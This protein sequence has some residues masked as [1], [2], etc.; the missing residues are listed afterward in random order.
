MKKVIIIVIF[1]MVLGSGS[2]IFFQSNY[3]NIENI[4][5]IGKEKLSEIEILKYAKVKRSM[6]LL[7][8]DINEVE[9]NL[10]KHPMIYSASVEKIYPNRLSIA[11]TLRH[12]IVSIYYS[13]C[14]I[15]IDKDL[16]ALSVDQNEEGLMTVYGLDIENFNL[17]EK[18]KVCDEDLM[19]SLVLLVELVEISDLNFTPSIHVENG[20]VF[21]IIHK[22]FII[23]FGNGDNIEKRF[24][25]FYNI[26]I[27]LNKSDVSTGIIDVSTDGLPIYKPFN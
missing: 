17:G 21:L 24:N 9:D 16:T 5:I 27:D 22:D 12:P 10:E 8:I 18:I 7:L 25:A 14:F 15:N 23:N 19:E 2:Y 13:N 20:D 3:F 6:N 4:E 1:L 11:Y 26:Y